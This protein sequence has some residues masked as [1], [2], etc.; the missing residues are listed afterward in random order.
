M[1]KTAEAIAEGVSIASAAARLAIR[2]R[3]LV[4][5]IAHDEQFDIVAFTPF[6]RETLIALADEQDEAAAMVKRQRKKA[7]GKFTDPDGT[8]DY[9]DRDTRNLRR[10]GR[11]YA[12]VA[13]A[14]RR[15]ADDPH[16]VRSLIEQARDAAWGDV[17]ANL[18][19]R[20]RVEGMRPDLD[21]DYERMR[22]ARMQSIRLVDIPR[23]AA[24]KRHRDESDTDAAPDA[25]P[26]TPS[27]RIS[28]VDVSELD[29]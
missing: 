5:T 22:A 14:L 21:P 11:Q 8:H 25:V 24:H 1:G 28:G 4:E 12:G 2:N 17:E 10:R 7:W 23:L 3:I 16:V 20:L 13:Q 26:A 9:R 27:P 6:A 15:M 29:S 19:R 18:Q